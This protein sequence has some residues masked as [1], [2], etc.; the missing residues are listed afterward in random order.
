ME[1]LDTETPIKVQIPR[2]LSKEKSEKTG[3]EMYTQC[4]NWSSC[5][6]TAIISYMITK[7][8][9]IYTFKDTVLS[10]ACTF[11]HLGSPPVCHTGEAL[12][13]TKVGSE[14][15]GAS[16]VRRHPS[17]IKIGSLVYTAYFH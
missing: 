6:S 15:R 10:S 2:G 12:R 9:K 3:Q 11:P 8:S 16:M 7:F 14:G 13:I 5:F 4:T 1:V 17:F